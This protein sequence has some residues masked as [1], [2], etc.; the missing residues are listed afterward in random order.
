MP[1]IRSVK[2]E[3]VS[4]VRLSSVSR[5]ARLTFIYMITQA[6]DIGLL[7]GAPR[8]LV[9]T[10]YP[11]DESVTAPMLFDWIDE[12]VA[13]GLIRRRETR[14]GVP[15]LQITNWA[16]HQRVDNAGRSQLGALLAESPDDP[17]HFAEGNGDPP[18]SAESRGLDQRPPISDLGSPTTDP[19]SPTTED[20]AAAAIA[21]SVAAN[22]G[23]A[24]HPKRPQPIP[25]I[26]GTHMR[27]HAAA[28]DILSAGV[29]LAFAE[30]VVYDAARAHTAED[31]VTSLKFFTAA[32]KRAWGLAQEAERSANGKNGG[33][34]DPIDAAF[35]EAARRINAKR[36]AAEATHA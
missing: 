27:S 19:R 30:V 5:D 13:G 33:H 31:Q 26:V 9:G 15:V 24:E 1:R 29:P 4:D 22:N 25:R 18:R 7:A 17:P 16:K 28:E 12:L 21:L 23:L 3:I 11:L 34:P 14:D 35:D 2:P 32:V 10:L 20:V 6:D 36:A 8:Q